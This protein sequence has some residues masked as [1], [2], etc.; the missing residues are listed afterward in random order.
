[1]APEFHTGEITHKFDLYSLG[2]IVMEMLTGKKG[3]QSIEDVRTISICHLSK[4]NFNIMILQ[5]KFQFPLKK[6]DPFHNVLLI[7][8][9]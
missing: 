2:V 8:I 7:A 4:S 1:M 3:Y 6:V 5:I 9:I